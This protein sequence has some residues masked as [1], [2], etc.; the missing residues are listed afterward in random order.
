MTR[1]PGTIGTFS[2]IF[3]GTFCRGMHE[4]RAI[5]YTGSIGMLIRMA[6]RQSARIVMRPKGGAREQYITGNQRG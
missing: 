6:A 1:S 5:L 2:G 4:H 3:S